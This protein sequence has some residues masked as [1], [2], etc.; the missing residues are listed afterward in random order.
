MCVIQNSC[1]RHTDSCVSHKDLCVCHTE[2]LYESYR[3][4]CESYRLTWLLAIALVGPVLSYSKNLNPN[5]WRWIPTYPM[6]SYWSMDSYPYLYL[7]SICKGLMINKERKHLILCIE[8]PQNLMCLNNTIWW[9][10]AS[11][12]GI[13]SLI[14][15]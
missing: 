7:V 2:L 13:Y 14:V 9:V 5:T 15:L 6:M 12:Y 4:M 10:R 3:L 11:L 8:I 1:M